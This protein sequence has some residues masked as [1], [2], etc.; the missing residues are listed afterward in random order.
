M[1]SEDLL[2]AIVIGGAGLTCFYLVCE[3]WSWKVIKAADLKA[4]LD[5]REMYKK[6]HAST[7]P[8]VIKA[9]TIGRKAQ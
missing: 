8:Y 4:M 5:V 1:R 3:C 7:R 9:R 2:L 6:L